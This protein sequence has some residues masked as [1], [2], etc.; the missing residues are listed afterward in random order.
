M[1]AFLAPALLSPFGRL[2]KP[3]FAKSPVSACLFK[4][5]EQSRFQ[6][7]SSNPPKPNPLFVCFLNQCPLGKLPTSMLM[8][9]KSVSLALPSFLKSR[10]RGYPSRYPTRTSNPTRQYVTHLPSFSKCYHHTH[11]LISVGGYDIIRK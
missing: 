11:Q 5:Y 10:I 1:P 8:I 7:C 3:S 9:P 4:Y 2:P 6:P